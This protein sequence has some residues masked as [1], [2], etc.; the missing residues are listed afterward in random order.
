MG[1]RQGGR[2]GVG[3]ALGA[4]PGP[5]GTSCGEAGPVADS[6][7]AEVAPDQA[8]CVQA[9]SPAASDWVGDLLAE[10]GTWGVGLG[11]WGVEPCAWAGQLGVVGRLAC[12]GE[13]GVGRPWAG[14]EGAVE[15]RRSCWAA[16]EVEQGALQLKADT[17]RGINISVWTASFE[18]S[19]SKVVTSTFRWAFSASNYTMGQ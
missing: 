5:A 14:R 6:A 10:A 12:P 11:T 7:E 9:P 18:K 3:P 2:Q 13:I 16:C 1:E 15:V 19:H 8:A 4:V 17:F